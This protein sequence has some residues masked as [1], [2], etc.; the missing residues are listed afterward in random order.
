M[1]IFSCADIG[2][3]GTVSA[4]NAFAFPIDGEVAIGLLPSP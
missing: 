1:T 4:V 2:K 3:L